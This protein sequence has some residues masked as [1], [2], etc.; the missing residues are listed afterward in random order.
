V[1]L[2]AKVAPKLLTVQ[3]VRVGALTGAQTG[4]P[5]AEEVVGVVPLTHDV[6]QFTVAVPSLRVTLVPE[7]K[8]AVK[9]VPPGETVSATAVLAPSP[10]T[11][12]SAGTT[13]A[14]VAVAIR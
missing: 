3:L 7:H 5:G 12:T 9:A 1:Q 14:A 11:A 13:M 6:V 10:S 4:V 8:Q 2:A